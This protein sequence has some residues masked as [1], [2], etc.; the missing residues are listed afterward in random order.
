MLTL[1]KLIILHQGI[2]D[3]ILLQ[4]NYTNHKVLLTFNTK[5]IKL[6]KNDF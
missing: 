1:N 4:K 2:I 3:K 5:S 6:K